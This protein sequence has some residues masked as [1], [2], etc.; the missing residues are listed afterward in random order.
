L[1]EKL[2][3]YEEYVLFHELMEIEYR[4]LSVSLVPIPWC[5][6]CSTNL[7]KRVVDKEAPSTNNL[8]INTGNAT[9]HLVG[10]RRGRI[11]RLFRA[12]VRDGSRLAEVAADTLL[13]SCSIDILVT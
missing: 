8:T 2:R 6:T 7:S 9:S 5:D 12:Y 4:M 10:R 1:S 11:E 13:S 3:D